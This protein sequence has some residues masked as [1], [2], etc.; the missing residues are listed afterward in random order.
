MHIALTQ[1]LCYNV[2]HDIRMP[3]LPRRNQSALCAFGK[4][5]WVRAYKVLDLRPGISL[6]ADG[7]ENGRQASMGTLQVRSLLR[8]PHAGLNCLI[9]WGGS[10]RYYLYYRLLDH[11]ILA[12]CASRQ[13]RANRRF[14]T[15]PRGLSPT[16]HYSL[17]LCA[18]LFAFQ[19]AALFRATVLA[20]LLG[21]PLRGLA[22]RARGIPRETA[23]GA[24][25]AT[26]HAAPLPHHMLN[27]V[28]PLQQILTDI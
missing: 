18:C 3:L 13:Q 25:L 7:D 10:I 16:A 26:R 11:M 1:P 2:A 19:C 21:H 28:K 4:F 14:T 15:V 23:G 6:H 27:P 5:L 9:A 20:P 24:Q 17:L 12:A 22:L 8:P